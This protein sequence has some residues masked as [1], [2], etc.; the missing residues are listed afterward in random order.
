M[1][2]QNLALAVAGAVGAALAFAATVPAQAGGVPDGK[3][4]CYG[5]SLKGHNDCAHAGQHECAGMSKMSYDKGDFKYVA[6]GTCAKMRPHGHA[7]S[8][9]SA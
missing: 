4:S 5:I 1:K 9:T 3:E 2:S 8:L 7:G 6:K